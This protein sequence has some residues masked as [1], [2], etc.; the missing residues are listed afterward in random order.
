MNNVDPHSYLLEHASIGWENAATPWSEAFGDIYWNRQGG[1]AEKQ[2][3]FI[4]V[5]NLRAR[6]QALPMVP[7]P[8]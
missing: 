4:E 5:N 2:F 1:L 7:S 6:W 8:K 3:V